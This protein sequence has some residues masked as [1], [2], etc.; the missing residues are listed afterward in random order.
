MVLRRYPQER[1][2]PQ[3]ILRLALVRYQEHS[4]KA[5]ELSPVTRSPFIQLQPD[6]AVRVIRGTIKH[7][8]FLA[9]YGIGSGLDIN[10]QSTSF[11][12]VIESKHHEVWSC[13]TDTTCET[14]PAGETRSPAELDG[15]SDG[16]PLLAT[17]AI[18]L[19]KHP[20]HQRRVRVDECEMRTG[21]DPDTLRDS[22]AFPF[23]VGFGPPLLLP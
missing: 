13:D 3:L 21:Y 17:Y 23:R 14:C 6:R 22:S 8:F 4:E 7:Q 2:L 20:H 1:S 19:N 11:K 16:P 10:G 18:A 9:I 5:R 15:L 12:I